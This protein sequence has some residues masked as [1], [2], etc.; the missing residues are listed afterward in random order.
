M[1]TTQ[2]VDHMKSGYS[3]EEL[4][5][6]FD[7]VQNQENWKLPI[8]HTVRDEVPQHQVEAA[9]TFYTGSVATIEDRSDGSYRV[10]AAGYYACIGA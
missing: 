3:D 9:I 5:A 2:W 4:S 8:D 1:N 6:A 10:T 7:L